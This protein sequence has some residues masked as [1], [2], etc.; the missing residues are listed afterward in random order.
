MAKRAVRATGHRLAR[1]VRE[2]EN[3]GSDVGELVFQDARR[4]RHRF[5]GALCRR[6]RTFEQLLRHRCRLYLPL[7]LV[8]GTSKLCFGTLEVLESLRQLRFLEFQ[9]CLLL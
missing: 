3:L 6:E 7:F 8:C 1:R 5:Q 9:H 4:L 2:V